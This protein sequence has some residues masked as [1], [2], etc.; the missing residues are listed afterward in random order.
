MHL[1]QQDY[2]G[3]DFKAGNQWVLHQYSFVEL[4]TPRQLHLN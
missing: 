2:A 4:L 1:T 3:G